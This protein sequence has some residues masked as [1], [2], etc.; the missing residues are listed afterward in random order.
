M[1][2]A[3]KAPAGSGQRAS[4]LLV[5]G[6]GI[7]GLW[8]ALTAARAGLRTILVEKDRLGAGPSGGLLGALM[9]HTP[10]RWNP[11]KQF[12]LEALISLEGEIAALEAET[13]M[14]TGYRRCGRLI[15]LPKEHLREI[16]RRNAL[17]AEQNWQVAGK[18]FRWSLID[19][20][21]VAGWPDE[22]MAFSGAVFETL[23][24]RVSPRLLLKVLESAV[25]AS[26]RVTILEG[27]EVEAFDTGEGRA[28]LKGGQVIRFG[29]A[30]LSAGTGSFP[31]LDHLLDAPVA[32]G[33]AVKGQAALFAAAVDPALPVIYRDGLYIVPHED[34]SVAVGSTSE[35]EFDNPRSTDERLDRLIVSARELVPLLADAPVS[36]RWAGV[37]PRAIGRDPMVGKLPEHPRL[38]ALTGGFKIS[39]GVAHSLAKAAV[40]EITGAGAIMLPHTFRTATHVDLLKEKAP[41]R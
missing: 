22:S 41:H 27:R 21:P 7:M 1:T 38:S 18:D 14:T 8:A 29:H 9:P 20:P 31:L 16:A 15:P 39:F 34:G 2:E 35:Q 36:E 40:D 10:D 3:D 37:R 12:Q 25:R 5:I 24:A 11:K 26:G 23:A 6:G 17:D 30:I 28:V 13:G 32:T 4:D 33:T 19:A